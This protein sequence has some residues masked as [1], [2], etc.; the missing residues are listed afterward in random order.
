MTATSAEDFLPLLSAGRHR[1]AR[2]GACFMEYASY[3]AGERWSDR[4]SCTHPS[5]ASLARLVND[6]TSDGERSVL[7]IY[8]PSVVGLNG[9]DPRVAVLLSVLAA[10]SAL[11]IASSM[12]Q[13]ALATGLIRCEQLLE[14]W[15]GPEVER[16]RMRIRTAFLLAPGTEAWAQD[17]ID[18]VSPRA[19]RI[20]TINDD[21]LLRT[22]AIGIADACVEDA[23]ARLARLLEQAIDECVAI[24]EPADVHAAPEERIPALV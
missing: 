13:G 8:I 5:L 12:R 16:A 4:P 10:S 1:N 3:L 24:L 11:P 18:Q 17:F 22:A 20:L 23:D 7:S 19:A 14:Q 21:A 15:D 9:D 6:L 2:R